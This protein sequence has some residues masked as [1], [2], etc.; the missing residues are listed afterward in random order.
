MLLS[1]CPQLWAVCQISFFDTDGLCP[2]ANLANVQPQSVPVYE[3]QRVARVAVVIIQN[4][5]ENRHEHHD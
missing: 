5:S 3:P 2:D 1:A 4:G